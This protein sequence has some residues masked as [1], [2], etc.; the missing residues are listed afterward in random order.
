MNCPN[1]KSENDAVAEYCT[2]CH[3]PFKKKMH[4]AAETYLKAMKRHRETTPI[5]ELNNP[6]APSAQGKPP[7][8]PLLPKVDWA[9]YAQGAWNLVMAY[10]RP[11]ALFVAG[12]LLIA[13]VLFISSS[14]FWFSTLGAKPGYHFSPKAS[15]SYIVGFQS[16]IKRWAERQGQLDTPMG[17]I[18][19][20]EIGTLSTESVG[21]KTKSSSAVR[22]RDREWLIAV[23]RSDRTDSKTY[24]GRTTAD[25]AGATLNASGQ[26]SARHAETPRLAKSAAFLFI[27]FPTSRLKAG[28]TWND[29]VEWIDTLGGWTVRWRALR[30]WR[31]IGLV[32]CG[33]KPCVQI[34]YR[35][36]LTARDF[37]APD[38]MSEARWSV[39][40]P[41]VGQG[42]VVFDTQHHQL[43]S[44][45][46]DYAATLRASVR[47]LGRIPSDLRVGSRVFHTAGEVVIDCKNRVSLQRN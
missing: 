9:G 13:G 26:V 20:E 39:A 23:H 27:W 24:P 37:T 28:R 4:S 32:P 3:A 21:G 30:Q 46:L 7:A 1:C 18:K 8:P 15:P 6:A 17:E 16:Q 10:R 45:S 2:F 5:E 44:H 29:T 41:V 34:A 31:V 12:L 19:I 25:P 47:D 35:A 22:L 38:W 43:V 40:S 14:G 36:E 11:L 33:E 42:E